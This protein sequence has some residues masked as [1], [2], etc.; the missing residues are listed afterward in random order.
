M[1]RGI[2]ISHGH[3]MTKK[4]FYTF[5]YGPNNHPPLFGWTP[6]DSPMAYAILRGETAY[7][8][9]ADIRDVEE[10]APRRFCGD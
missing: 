4:S 6:S 5:Q 10:H 8:D 9:Y 2:V 1:N 7:G 3:L